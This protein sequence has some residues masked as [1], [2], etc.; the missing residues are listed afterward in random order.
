[1][2]MATTLQNNLGYKVD[3]GALSNR[4]YKAVGNGVLVCTLAS[5]YDIA[6]PTN[7][8]TITGAEQ[9]QLE[10]GPTATTYEPYVGQ[11]YPVTLP[12][13]VYG[14]AGVEDEVDLA[15]GI[16]T[17]RTKRLVFDGT[18]NWVSSASN[19]NETVRFYI[20]PSAASV[21]FSVGLSTHV[22]WRTSG[23]SGDIL[24]AQVS[25]GNI[26]Y[27]I[28]AGLLPS[29][30]LDSFKT[31]LAAQY[32]AGTPVQVLYQLAT[33]QIITIPKLTIPSLPGLNT[34]YTD[35]GGPTTVTGRQGLPGALAQ[36]DQ[37]IAD[38]QAIVLQQAADIAVLKA[39]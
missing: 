27:R 20:T 19:N 8:V 7:I 24:G 1:M 26:Y 18:E 12:E 29:A 10:I 9:I 2:V 4:T 34:V 28:Y 5:I 13:A 17:R 31:W 38:L 25:S 15:R 23:I 39:K 3:W 14:L 16:L 11:T 33:P 37:S 21:N 36:R 6:N 32:A 30:T 22:P 35:A